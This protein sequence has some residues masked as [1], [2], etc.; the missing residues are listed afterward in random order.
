[1]S[2]R[3]KE[4]RMRSKIKQYEVARILDICPAT[5]N[6]YE[7]GV[8]RPDIFKLCK[9][10]DI[11]NVSVDYLLKRTEIPYLPEKFWDS[12]DFDDASQKPLMIDFMIKYC[13]LDK[14][15]QEIL[16]RLLDYEYSLAVK[17]GKAISLNS[18]EAKK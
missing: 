17:K 3:L 10:A 16:R 6:R 15:H 7:K 14:D 1:M 18:D 9:I 12:A 13:S 11:Y 8:L 5:Y 2:N 4:M